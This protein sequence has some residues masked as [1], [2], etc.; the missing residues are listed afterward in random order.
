ML[1]RWTPTGAACLAAFYALSAALCNLQQLC[2]ACTVY[3]HVSL[4]TPEQPLCLTV[5]I[6]PASGQ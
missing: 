5:Q 4:P 6:C 2:A 3:R 1:W